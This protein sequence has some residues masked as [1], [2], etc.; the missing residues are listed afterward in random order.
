MLRPVLSHWLRAIEE[1]KGGLDQTWE[2]LW[3]L[4]LTFKTV[5]LSQRKA[6]NMSCPLTS[7]FII[8]NKSKELQ[9]VNKGSLSENMGIFQLWIQSRHTYM[10]R[11]FISSKK[12]KKKIIFHKLPFLASKPLLT[13]YLWRFFWAHNLIQEFFNQTHTSDAYFS[14]YKSPQVTWQQ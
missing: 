1:G 11:H 5:S 12:K 13:K 14:I 3:E 2:P 9:K 4:W 10:I 6:L 7:N 8:A